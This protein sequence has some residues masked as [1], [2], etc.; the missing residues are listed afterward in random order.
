VASNGRPPSGRPPVWTTVIVVVGSLCV[1][2]LGLLYLSDRT[3][4]SDLPDAAGTSTTVPSPSMSVQ[5][6]PSPNVSPELTPEPTSTPV[7]PVV[8]PVVPDVSV[9]VLNQSAVSGL[10]AR[11]AAVLA[12]AG[13]TVGQVD[14][15]TLGT[16]STTLY[17]PV[18]LESAAASFVEAF[19]SVGRTRPA[20]EGLSVGAL[21]LV[22]AQPDAEAVV[23]GIEGSAAD[24]P[25]PVGAGP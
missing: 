6:S 3:T 1:V 13:W 5:A 8:S 23:V 14:D 22:L 2:A 7:A 16:P 12:D 15:A 25:A 19:P 20:F 18:G 4:E 10:G 24:V 21:T 17:V 11:A 9:D